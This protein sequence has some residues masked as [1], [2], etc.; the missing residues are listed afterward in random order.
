M[1]AKVGVRCIELVGGVVP[2][3]GQ[4]T[5]QQS[6]AVVTSGLEACL[7][8]FAQQS[9]SPLIPAIVHSCSSECSGIPAK[10]LPPSATMRARDGNHFVIAS[11]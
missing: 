10:T 9:M 2:D 4:F 1:T 3:E 8:A 6:R 5:A 7:R 11:L